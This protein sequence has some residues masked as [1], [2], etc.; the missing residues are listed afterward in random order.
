[1]KVTPVSARFGRYK[2][3]EEFELPDRA[4]KVFIRAGKLR[5]VEQTYQTRML[6]AASPMRAEQPATQPDPAPY[7]YKTDGTPRKRPGR[8]AAS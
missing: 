4:A 8:P 7:G 2:P 5:Q 6:A 1:M 3:G